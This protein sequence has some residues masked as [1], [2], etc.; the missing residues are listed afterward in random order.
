MAGDIQGDMDVEYATTVA[1]RAIQLMSQQSVPATPG[2]FSVWFDYAMGT[3]PALRKTID[4]LIGNKRKF[5]ASI[6]HELYVTYVNPQS[7]SADT[8]DFPEQL[9]GVITSAKHFLTTAIADNRT[10]IAALGEVSSEFQASSDPRP[11][12]EKLMAELSRATT[13]ASAL[14]TNFATTSQEL[15]SIRNSLKEAEQRSNTDALTGLANRRSLDEFLRSAQIMA[16]EKGEPLSVLMI[17]IDHF[18]KFNDSYGHQIGDQVLRLVAKV[19]Q[20]N[21]RDQDLA[22]RYG[23][24]ELMAVLPGVALDI[25]A[26]IAER[27]R[28]RVSEARL[29]RRTTGQE[30][31]SVT[32]SIGV[33]QFRMAESAEAM[34]ER[35]DR[36]LYQ[37]KRSGRNRTVTENEIEDEVVAA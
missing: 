27:I 4:I 32:V 11:I 35:C 14:E 33:A 31:S 9:R 8:G 16:M 18:K 1:D 30:I 28:H 6:N 19:L 12:I 25:C 29:T 22:A 17:D 3:S 36:G 26:D 15:D 37:A 34:I 21:V 24:E 2:N 7:D 23:G 5:D 13:R 10:Q 20:D